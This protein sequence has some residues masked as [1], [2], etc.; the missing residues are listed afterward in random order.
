MHEWSDAVNFSP[1]SRFI[2]SDLA[3]GDQ[4]RPPKIPAK[5]VLIFKMEILAIN[6]SSKPLTEEEKAARAKDG[7]QDAVPAASPGEEPAKGAQSPTGSEAPAAAEPKTAG[8]KEGKNGG[9]EGKTGGEGKERSKPAAAS[10]DA[11]AARTKQDEFMESANANSSSASEPA[12]SPNLHV[13]TNFSVLSLLLLACCVAV[14]LWLC[15]RRRRSGSDFD[16]RE[17]GQFAE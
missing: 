13:G 1:S 4:G 5:A 10:Q 16:G 7:T 8:E 6:G 17:M 14:P 9:G 3:Y 12:A 2:P 11:S 15:C